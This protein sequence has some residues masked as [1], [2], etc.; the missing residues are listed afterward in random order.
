MRM[1]SAP[2]S[3]RCRTQ[4]GPARAS[5]RSRTRI[6]ASGKVPSGD[7]STMNPCAPSCV[8][9]VQGTSQGAVAARDA[10]LLNGDRAL[11]ARAFMS[12]LAA[13]EDIAARFVDGEGDVR[14]LPGLR[15]ELYRL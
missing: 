3:A 13:E 9:A 4:V 8:V 2:Q 7:D 15:G 12:R 1:T 11:H 6:F 14:D 5:V 10:W